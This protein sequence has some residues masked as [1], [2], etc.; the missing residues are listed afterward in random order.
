MGY[1]TRLVAA[2]GLA[3]AAPLLLP[4]ASFAQFLDR[5][6]EWGHGYGYGR[7]GFDIG[8][9]GSAFSTPSWPSYYPVGPYQSYGSYGGPPIVILN[10]Y[11]PAGGYQ[12]FYPP[13]AN[14]AQP[15]YIRVQV[16]AGAQVSFDGS[17][18]QQTGTDRLFVTPPMQ[19]GPNYTYQVAA[20]WQDNG[21]QRSE[22]RTVRVRAGQTA[23]VRFTP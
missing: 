13:A 12:S 17:P 7:S 6:H 15:A 4:S 8:K 23:N 2:L 10:V 9:P 11:P 14:P 3:L 16:P 20:R 22:E 18:T 5:W 1:R 21:R 19:A